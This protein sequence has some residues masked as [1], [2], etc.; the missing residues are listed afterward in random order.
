MEHEV[1]GTDKVSARVRLEIYADA[2][3]LRLIEAL[4]TDFPALQTLV[5]EERFATLGRAYIDAHPS[6]HFSLRYFGRHM[7]RFL[8]TAL[9]SEPWL[10]ELAAFEW[11][12]G[13]AFDAAD[14]SALTAERV[15]AVP[16]TEWPG[17]RLCLHPSVRRLDLRWN[18]P[19]IWQA[20]DQQES[21]EIGMPQEH[22]ISWLVWRRD[23]R[24]YY[25][26]LGEDEAWA[27]EQAAAGRTF[28]ELCEGLCTWFSEAEVP[29][30]AAGLLKGWVTEGLLATSYSQALTA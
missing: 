20:V 5:G 1:V 25:R 8:A 17:M 27:L 7:H 4:A 15:G 14:G 13:E 19:R 12:L 3:R 24:V 18:V 28:G 21:P 29:A 23:L 6:E 22:E 2:Y 16:P 30:H 11:A 10:A 26:S 9:P